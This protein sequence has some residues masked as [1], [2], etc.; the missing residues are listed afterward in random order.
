MFSAKNPTAKLGTKKIP[1]QKKSEL[2]M[3]LGKWEPYWE[4]CFLKPT[5]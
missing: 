2:G 5:L 1:T 3:L 4:T